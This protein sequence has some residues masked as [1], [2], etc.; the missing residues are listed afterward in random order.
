MVHT[1]LSNIT[2]DFASLDP[3]AMVVIIAMV[4]RENKVVKVK[5]NPPSYLYLPSSGLR[6]NQNA[7][8]AVDCSAAQANTPCRW[9]L[10]HL[11]HE[12]AR[13]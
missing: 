9:M 5:I 4:H 13:S 3:T 2:R 1:K 12:S 6:T 11:L 10:G 7:H 8:D